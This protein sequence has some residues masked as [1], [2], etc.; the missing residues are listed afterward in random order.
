MSKYRNSYITTL[1]V[2]QLEPRRGAYYYLRID[3]DI[4]NEF[5]NKRKT[6]FICSLDHKIE[7][8]CGLNHLGDGHFFHHTV[9][10]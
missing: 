9:Q 6:R 3:K 1:N 4:I 5:E 2:Q 8:Q 10:G 7:Y